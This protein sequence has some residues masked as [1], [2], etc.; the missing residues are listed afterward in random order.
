MTTLPIRTDKKIIYPDSDGQPMADNTQQFR[1]IVL[2]KENLELIFADAADVFVAG[3]LLWYPV[4]GH[5][6]I[7]VAPDVLV[8]FGR[9]KGDR[10]SYQQWRENNI[11]P[12]VVFEILSPGNRLKEMTKKLQFYDRYGVEEYYIYDPETNELNGLYKK[13]NRLNVIEDIEDWVSPRLQIRFKVSE[14]SL[15][16]Y[17]PD[18]QKF[19]TTLELNQYAEQERQ[20]ANQESQRAEQESLRAEQ[21]RQRAEQESQRADQES[22]RADQEYE[23]AERLLAQLRA[24]GIQPA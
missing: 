10:G 6:E 13:D 19:L 1:W 4:E 5:P 3:D 20:R 21:E 8:A 24:M 16:I 2:I 12:Q 9:A 11:A 18:G 15:D 23:R 17:R 14:D 22:Q 7:R